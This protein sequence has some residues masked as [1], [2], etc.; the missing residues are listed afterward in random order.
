M[1][2]FLITFVLIVEF[3]DFIELY[4]YSVEFLITFILIV[5]FFDFITYHFFLSYFQLHNFR[6]NNITH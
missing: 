2:I 3:F 4:Y 1:F 5:E 6:Q